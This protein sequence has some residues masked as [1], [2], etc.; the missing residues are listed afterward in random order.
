MPI[1][2]QCDS[3]QRVLQVPDSAEG[4]QARCPSCQTMIRVTR[5]KSTV[6]P[7]SVE[8]PKPVVQ[9]TVAASG[10][11]VVTCTA[12]GKKLRAPSTAAGKA[13]RCPGCQS[14]I[15]VPGG[16]P[17]SSQPI[18]TVRAIPAPVI[19][20]VTAVPAYS[21]SPPTT[22]GSAFDDN[23]LWAAMPPAN[24][25]T[26]YGSSGNYGGYSNPYAAS[27]SSARSSSRSAS[28]TTQY[29]IIGVLMMI[30]AG[31]LVLGC[32]LRPIFIVVAL[33]NLPPNAVI[34]WGR[35]TPILIGTGIGIV[36]ALIVAFVM[37]Q[38]GSAFFNQTDYKAAK[39]AAIVTAIPCLGSC[40]F[41]VGI[42]A[43][44]LIFSDRA[45]RDFDG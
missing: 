1:R 11:I 43:C 29:S 26:N 10:G 15:P 5:A 14:T 34:D 40:L 35:M 33:S 20:Q 21:I 16:A 7:I 38:G 41:P 13:I 17:L 24:P 4:K 36:I 9:P 22:P 39:G 25:A 30:W 6:Q 27:G 42:W 45:R 32:I 23:S 2:I 28:P 18:P 3:C 44:V 37:F 19:P 12:C 8:A 31:L